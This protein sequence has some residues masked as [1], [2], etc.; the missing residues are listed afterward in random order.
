MIG[1]DLKVRRLDDGNT[2]WLWYCT[3]RRK[4][5]KY[6]EKVDECDARSRFLYLLVWSVDAFIFY[7]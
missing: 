7:L 5:R 1:K 6:G 3:L 2:V 4:W